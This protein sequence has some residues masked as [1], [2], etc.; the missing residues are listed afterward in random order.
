MP[1]GGLLPAGVAAAVAGIIV[2][3]LSWG[4]SQRS[5]PGNTLGWLLLVGAAIA[6]WAAA[7]AWGAAVVSLWSMGAALAALSI[8]AWNSPPARRAASNRRAGMLPEAGEP[9]HIARRI[10][11]FFIV[12]IGGLVSAIALAVTARWL[13]AAGGA[14]EADANVI[15]LFASPLGWTV[16]AFLLLMTQSHLR[17]FVI[18]AV[19]LAAALPA[20]VTGSFQ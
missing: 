4:R 10:T 11:T 5:I 15:A 20:L 18:L 3:R 16:I 8:A 1:G 2:L 6:G 19:P 9:A 14:S 17:R 12:T 13:A 7:G